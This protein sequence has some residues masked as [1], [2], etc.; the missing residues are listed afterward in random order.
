MT[1]PVNVDPRVID[2]IVQSQHA[3]M[4][5]QTVLAEARG[6][7]YQ[8]IAQSAAIAVQ[9]AADALRGVTSLATAATG[10]ALSQYLATGDPRFLEVLPQARE[11]VDGAIEDFSAVG[12]AAARLMTEFPA[13]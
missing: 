10:A 4:D 13:G 12:T 6:K 8:A 9:D 11:M 2:A 5:P 1:D 3:T 7:A